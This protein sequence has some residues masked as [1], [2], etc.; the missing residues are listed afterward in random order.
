MA[1]MAHIWVNLPKDSETIMQEDIKTTAEELDALKARQVFLQRKLE[2]LLKTR[3]TNA[4][5][6]RDEAQ[7]IFLEA[8]MELEKMTKEHEAVRW[9]AG[10]DHK[11]DN[12]TA[13]QPLE[14]EEDAP[15]IVEAPCSLDCRSLN[16]GWKSDS[17]KLSAG[18]PSASV[19]HDAYEEPK[20]TLSP[21]IT[22][23]DEPLPE[24]GPAITEKSDIATIFRKKVKK[25]KKKSAV[26]DP[27]EERPMQ[28]ELYP[29]GEV[30]TEDFF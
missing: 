7:A 4:Q 26:S 30:A 22:V 20:H 16:K 14:S 3:E 24:A 17:S 8:E 19:T 28:E 9:S 25:G 15:V 1:G 10:I 29:D 2:S 21:G 12:V 11:F 18:S 23:S 6:R 27:V 13:S 5:K